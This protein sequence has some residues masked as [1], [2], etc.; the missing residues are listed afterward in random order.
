[1]ISDRYFESI[2][3]SDKISAYTN[4]ELIL[5]STFDIH[6]IINIFLPEDFDEIRYK[7][8]ENT[9]EVRK[10]FYHTKI[11]LKSK[12][13]K[14]FYIINKTSDEWFYLEYCASIRFGDKGKITNEESYKC[15]QLDGLINCIKFTLF[16]NKNY[17][18]IK[19]S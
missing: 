18:Y 2:K 8:N 9:P 16:S 12:N 19:K 15:D 1:M 3:F 13:N 5:L 14:I 10:N 17:Q 11:T 7:L 6:T 4:Q